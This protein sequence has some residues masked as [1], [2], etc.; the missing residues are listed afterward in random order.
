MTA[1]TLTPEP[2]CQLPDPGGDDLPAEV[3]D[4]LRTGL[5]LPYLGPGLL[6][7]A[8]AGGPPRDALA[9]VASLT[10]RSSVPGK[11][12]HRLTQAAQFIENFKHRRTLVAGMQAAFAVPSEPGPLH[13]WLVALH[14]P[15]LV[16]T[17]Y[18]DTLREALAEAGDDWSEI[19]AVSPGEHV[20]RWTAAYAS[21]GTRLDAPSARIGQPGHT[22]LYRPWGGHAPAGQYLVSDSDFVEVLTEIDIQ[23]PIPEA[24][25]RLRLAR[26]FLFIGCRFD[27]QLSRGFARQ[28]LKRSA[29]P[30]WAWLPGPLTRMEA[31]FLQEQ[32]IT[33]LG[34]P[35]D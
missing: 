5:L 22:L 31:R 24:V 16:H 29:G 14:P 27:D 32:Q 7:A 33:R 30:H 13:R 25:Q 11:I 1:A 4:R 6:A 3:H 34:A 28:I 18:D 35:A 8:R 9:L 26:G 23:T 10:A 19:Q 2:T 20:G 12:R 21:D 15:M 17:W